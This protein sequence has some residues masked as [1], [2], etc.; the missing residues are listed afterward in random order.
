MEDVKVEKV[1]LGDVLFYLDGKIDMLLKFMQDDERSEIEYMM[2]D[3]ETLAQWCQGRIDARKSD[4][5]TLMSLRSQ[6]N[7]LK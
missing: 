3:K 5:K 6:I 4:I 2:E 7:K 1:K